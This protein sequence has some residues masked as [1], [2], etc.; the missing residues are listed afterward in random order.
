[1][2]F[3]FHKHVNLKRFHSRA[4][5]SLSLGD[6]DAILKSIFYKLVLLIGNFSFPRDNAPMNVRGPV[7]CQVNIGAEN[8]LIPSSNKPFP[9]AMLTQISVADWC[10]WAPI[11][12]CLWTQT[13][14]YSCA[15]TT[16]SSFNFVNT[17]SAKTQRFAGPLWVK[18]TGDRWIPFTNGQ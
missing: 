16:C 10:H 5:N 1:M 9:E 15:H 7:W 2:L 14:R 3:G 6:L 17:Q 11:G 18:S 13:L 8:D 12:E 4:V